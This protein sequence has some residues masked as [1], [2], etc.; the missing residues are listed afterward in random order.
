MNIW[1]P[2][3]IVSTSVTIGV[4]AFGVVT[5]DGIDVA[6][7]LAGNQPNME[8]AARTLRAARAYLDKAEHDKGGHRERAKQLTD[9]AIAEVDKGVAYAD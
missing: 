5:K 7:A 4:F 6:P 1:K 9:Q 2:L 8:A 3:A